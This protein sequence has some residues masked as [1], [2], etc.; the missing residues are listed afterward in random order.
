MRILYV[1]LFSVCVINGAVS[2]SLKVMTYN[3]RYSTANDGVNAWSNRKEKVFD[4]IRKNS[5]D[6]FG[7]QEALHE[8]MQ[9]LASA[10][11]EYTYVGVGRDDGKEKGEYTAI[12]YKKSRLKV[13]NS[14]SFWLSETPEI[15]GSMGWDAA[16]TRMATVCTFEDKVTQKSFRMFTSHFDHVGKEAQRNSAA[17]L[18]GSVV[19]SS[20]NEPMPALVCGDFNVEPTEE[21]YKSF[22]R[23]KSPDLFDARPVENMN[24]TFCG[25]EKGKM[26]CRIID[27]VFH[28]A[29]WKVESFE[30]LQDN[31]GKYYP[32][33]HLPVLVT[34]ALKP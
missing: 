20:I 1:L 25:F 19:G 14:R 30:V 18:S 32:S 33:D 29:E 16:I 26:E 34:L 4:L 15:P 5:P 3:I 22:F 10:L 12:F 9:D 28:T 27:Y 8:Q 31:D 6:A 23:G 7:V 24:G 13:V 11:P 21:A 2:Q 17:F